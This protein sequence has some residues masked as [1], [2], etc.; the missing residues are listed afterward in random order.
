MI[1]F[2]IPNGDDRRK[3]PGHATDNATGVW[4]PGNSRSRDAERPEGPGT[5]HLRVPGTRYL[6]AI[7][8]SVTMEI[9]SASS[10]AWARIQS[11]TACW[12]VR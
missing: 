5:R 9:S 3:E 12:S 10:P 4:A 8:Q 6:V 7:D 1:I 11:I 2:P